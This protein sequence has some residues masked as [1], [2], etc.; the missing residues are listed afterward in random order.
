ML[1]KNDRQLAIYYCNYVRSSVHIDNLLISKNIFLRRR[2]YTIMCHKFLGHITQTSQYLVSNTIQIRTHY[3]WNHWMNQ[4]IHKGKINF[5]V[6]KQNSLEMRLVARVIK[7]HP[8]PSYLDWYLIDK[9]NG[10]A[11]LIL[12]LRLISVVFNSCS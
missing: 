10:N 12:W 5:A 6:L 3:T 8:I 11:L 2:N 7:R 1:H 9:R 4:S